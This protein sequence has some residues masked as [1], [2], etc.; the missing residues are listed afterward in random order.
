MEQKLVVSS[1]VPGCSHPRSL[2]ACSMQLQRG[3]AWEMWSCAFVSG[4]Q[5]V[6]VPNCI[7]FCIHPSLTSERQTVFLLPFEHS[8]IQPSEGKR[9][10]V[11][12]VKNQEA[13][14]VP[15]MHLQSGFLLGVDGDIGTTWGA[16]S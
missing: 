8:N 13:K 5:M 14:L 10:Q 1:L 15:F 6:A 4:R 11:P 16:L 7:L 3:K 12:F 9:L 2:I